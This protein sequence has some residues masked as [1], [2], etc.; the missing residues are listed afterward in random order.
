MKR[1]KKMFCLVVSA[2]EIKEVIGPFHFSETT[3]KYLEEEKWS[4]PKNKGGKLWSKAENGFTIF[5]SIEKFR[6]VEKE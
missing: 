1:R 2:R 5:A 3:E 4:P 6:S